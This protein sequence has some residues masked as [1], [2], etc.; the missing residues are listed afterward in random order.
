M[1]LSAL[2]PPIL[3]GLRARKPYPSYEAALAE[4]DGYEAADIVSVVFEKTKALKVERLS[5]TNAFLIASLGDATVLDFGGACG[6]D[7]FIARAVTG[8]PRKWTVVETPA[9]VAKAK[10]LETDELRFSTELEP[11]ELIY[12]SGALQCVDRPFDYLEKLLNLGAKTIVFN[13]LGLSKGEDVFTIHRSKLS[14]NGP[15]PMPPGIEDRWVTYP[16]IFPSKARFMSMV[17]ERYDIV[18]TFADDSGIFPVRRARIEGGG[19]LAR[20]R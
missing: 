4:C 10:I 20:L 18:F 1:N 5:S 14:W 15:G 12:T 16:F 19:M 11:A 13:R 17:Q 9:M 8:K 6:A 7:Y 3:N 2:L